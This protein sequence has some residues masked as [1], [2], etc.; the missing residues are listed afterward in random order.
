MKRDWLAPTGA[1]GFV[2]LTWAAF[3]VG[4]PLGGSYSANDVAGF[5]KGSH[6]VAVFLSLYFLV[7][8]AIGLVV[9]LHRL[10]GAIQSST[11][12]SIF[13]A[14]AIGGTTAWAA[15]CV[16]AV[17]VPV[18]MAFGGHGVVL[19][20][21][22]VYTISEIGW[23][24]AFGAGAVLFGAALVTFAAGPVAVPAAVR[25]GTLVAGIAALAGAAWFPFFLVY[26]WAIGMGLWLAVAGRARATQVVTQPA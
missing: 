25:W 23:A 1:F 10:R 4:N 12:A 15:G 9:L 2:V 24:I 3:I 18:A 6:H 17:A 19:G 13:W 7:F 21:P 11:R 5:V 14:L 20:A 22:I 16:V 8:G 26:I